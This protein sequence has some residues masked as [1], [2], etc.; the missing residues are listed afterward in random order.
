MD[1]AVWQISKHG[2]TIRL[3]VTPN[4]PKND[5]N[6]VYKDGDGN[7]SLKVSTTAQPEKGKANKA[8]IAILSKGFHKAKSDFTVISGEFGRNK[9][10]LVDGETETIKLWLLSALEDMEND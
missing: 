8:V 2:L 5:I 10:V 7:M 6:G 4:A 1:T 9:T 3:R